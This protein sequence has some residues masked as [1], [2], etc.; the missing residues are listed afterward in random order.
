[1]SMSTQ[2]TCC[3]DC[4]ALSTSSNGIA[5]DIAIVNSNISKIVNKYGFLISNTLDKLADTKLTKDSGNE[6]LKRLNHTIPTKHA[7]LDVEIAKFKKLH[8]L[9]EQ[10]VR[11]N[12][13]LFFSIEAAEVIAHLILDPLDLATAASGI[14]LLITNI[15]AILI[16]ILA[17]VTP[18]LD[19]VITWVLRTA[20]NRKD[21]I[22]NAELHL[23]AIRS[24]KGSIRMIKSL[25]NTLNK[26]CIQKSISC[27]K[28]D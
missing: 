15:P 25:T 4:R 24:L 8:D 26:N 27:K 20:S 18:S 21:N 2:P 19:R 3:S 5:R 13:W 6:L 7:A 1:M 28:N 10:N 14:A 22:D 11:V 17:I 12:D 16:A 23:S 9:V